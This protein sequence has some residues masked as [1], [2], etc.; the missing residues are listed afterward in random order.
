MYKGSFPGFGETLHG[1]PIGGCYF[2]L[3]A[4]INDVSI[5]FLRMLLSGDDF[6]AGAQEDIIV[7][8]E[9]QF[10]VINLYG[11]HG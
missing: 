3:Y 4:V 1:V 11:W 5:D 9:E 8:F 7:I 2:D 10:S 6:R